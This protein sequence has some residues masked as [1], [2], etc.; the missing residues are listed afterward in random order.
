MSH[1]AK[2]VI[3]PQPSVPSQDVQQAL[4]AQRVSA[5]LKRIYAAIAPLASVDGRSLRPTLEAVCQEIMA[6]CG[7]DAAQLWL[8]E[9]LGAEGPSSHRLTYAAGAGM[10]PVPAEHAGSTIALQ[11]EALVSQVFHE[12]R[13]CVVPLLEGQAVDPSLAPFFVGAKAALLAPIVVET[14]SGDGA[15]VLGMLVL[16]KKACDPECFAPDD[17]QLAELLAGHVALALEQARM[18]RSAQER[19]AIYEHGLRAVTQTAEMIS[20]TLHLEEVAQQVVAVIRGLLG[21]QSAWLMIYDEET[22]LLRLAA[23]S[24]WDMPL[25]TEVSLDQS[26]AGKVFLTGQPLFVPDVQAEPLFSAKEEA[27]R[28]GIVAML[29]L[30]LLAQGRVVGVLGLNPARS[31]DGVV[32]N[33][34]D[35]PDSE[36]LHVFTGQVGVAVQNAQLYDR[37]QTEHAFAE[38]LAAAAERHAREMETIF[39]SMAEGV[40]V[41]DASG[42]V[43]RVNRAGAVLAGL[44]AAQLVQV[45]STALGMGLVGNLV[46]RQFDLT[47]HPLI[48]QALAGEVITGQELMLKRA[49]GVQCFLKMSVAPLSGE[50]GQVTGAVAILE[51]VTE[52][53]QRQREQLAV[54]WVAAALNHPLDVK[55]TLDTAVEALTAA[56]G[57]DHSAIL[58]ADQSQRVLQ[59]AASRGYGE[60][61]ETTFTEMPVNAPFAPCAAFRMRKVQVSSSIPSSLLPRHPLFGMLVRQGVQ[62]SL[63]APL[64][65]QDQTLGVLVCS[66]AQPHEFLPAEQQVARA[67]ADQIALAVLNARLY[68][69]VADYGAWQENERNLLQAIIDALPAGVILRDENGKL[70]MY[71]EAALHLAVNGAEVQAARAVGEAPQVP[72]WE[73]VGPE[74]ESAELEV[75]PSQQVVLTGEAVNEIQC[76]LRQADGRVV[77]VLVNAAPVRA[78]DG[79]VTRGVAVFQD[80]TALKE[81]E[82]HKDEFIS[83]ASHELRGPLTVIR[84]QAQLLQRQLRRQERQGQLPPGMLHIME[85]MEGIESQTARLNDLVNDLLDVSRIQAGKLVLQRSSAE[86]MTIIAKVIQHWRPAATNHRVLIQADV[87]PDGVTGQWDARRVEQ[88]LSNLIG[89]ALKYSPDGGC[90]TIKVGVDLAAGAVLASVQDEG[91]GIP[92]EALPHLFERFYRAGNVHSISG[93]GLGLYISKQLTTAHGGDLWAE[94]PGVGRGSTFFLRLPLAWAGDA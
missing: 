6:C 52:Q 2:Q 16:L 80:I 12:R 84:G 49:D 33:P 70:F 35:G 87:P 1:Q 42:Q 14:S 50:Q 72:S 48:L 25:G 54:G 27:A 40:A 13:A 44:S 74:G 36:W 47:G 78:A 85:S 63:S 29:G 37:L 4:P 68:D 55:E 57:A 32:Q 24:G 30:P 23:I 64:I 62:A 20:S 18:L 58:L 8:A 46:S 90:V 66:Y 76:F 94:S 34:L 9:K 61:I 22:D 43:V 11:G 39:E 3:H 26:V 82:R 59:V 89:N 71:N 69:E 83:T 53:H 65:V 45:S 7:V 92:P 60:E 88:I 81:L 28:V 38:R 31:V 51:D 86:L 10:V 41:F 19:A 15:S 67:I 93:T 21:V 17:V 79:T 91:M 77:P 75:I 5:A 73:V 56:M